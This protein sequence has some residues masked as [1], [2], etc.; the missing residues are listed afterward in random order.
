MNNKDQ[1]TEIKRIEW[2]S[3]AECYLKIRDYDDHKKKVVSELFQFL[4]T[5][6]NHVMIKK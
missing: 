3:E 4:K 5:Y 1:Y 2:L 6:E